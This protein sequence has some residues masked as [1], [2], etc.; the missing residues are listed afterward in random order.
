MKTRHLL[1]AMIRYRP[2]LYAVNAVIWTLIHLSPLVPGLI[3]QRFFNVFD[4]TG[5]T[6]SLVW[7]LIALFLAAAVGRAVLFITGVFVDALHRFTMSSLLRR[8]ILGAILQ[9]PGAA[10]LRHST[11]DALSR[12]QEDAGYAE[13]TISWTL[14]VI[15]W[16]LF[17][18][19][20]VGILFNISPVI[21]LF[22]FAPLV[23]V[24]A[25]AQFAAGRIYRLRKASREATGRAT[26]AI[27][28]MFD[29]VQA[30]KVAAAEKHVIDHYRK[31]GDERRRAMLRDR[32]LNQFLDSIGASAVSLGTGAILLLSASS[33]TGAR[34]A[35][36]DFALFVYYLGFV[37]DFTQFFGR[38]LA[39]YRQAGVSFDRMLDLISGSPAAELVAHTPMMLTS[40]EDRTLAEPRSEVQETLQTLHARGLSYRYPGSGRGVEGVNLTLPCGSFTVIT[41]RIASGKTTLLR[42]LLGLLPRE[43]GDIRWNDQAVDDPAS[44]LVPPRCAYI[45]QVPWLFSGT[46]KENILLGLP[47]EPAVLEQAIHFAVLERDID[48]MP[49]GLE[50]VI[51]PK[52]V[53]LSGGQ[54]QRTAAARMFAHRADLYVMDDLSSALDVETE[55]LLWS[56]LANMSDSTCLVVSHRQAAFRRA[57]TIIVL[58]DGRIESQGTLKELLA[59]SPEMQL[60]WQEQNK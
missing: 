46:L 25:A 35:L 14:D 16:G 1:W 3:I 19:I 28:E 22:V 47:E 59:T 30:I 18:I 20:S 55:E 21:T 17:A 49:A 41:G 34:L 60:L 38:F 15:G 51:G 29:A 6:P 50:T 9:Q 5:S 37:T 57:D 12:M 31:L 48:Q 32:L 27:G 53:R 45:S 24:I 56:R 42:V 43:T 26:S 10:A 4:Q 8:N 13:N 39:Q 44:F 52:G 36:G 23:G 33:L 7:K 40:S 11:G 54:M 58:K 2:G